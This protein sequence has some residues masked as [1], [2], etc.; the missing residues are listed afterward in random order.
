MQVQFCGFQCDV[1]RSFAFAWCL[2]K[3][4]T[5]GLST[6]DVFHYGIH[7]LTYG[8]GSNDLSDTCHVEFHMVKYYWYNIIDFCGSSCG[9][10]ESCIL[11][12]C[13]Q[14]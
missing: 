4:N 1:I 11:I 6:L 13:Y 9:L 10:R 8:H 12:D 5:L 14:N 3:L 7:K 2:E